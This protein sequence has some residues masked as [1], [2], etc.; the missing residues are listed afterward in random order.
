MSLPGCGGK[1]DEAGKRAVTGDRLSL[2]HISKPIIVME[3]DTFC[4]EMEQYK[5]IHLPEAGG[6]LI[7]YKDN[8]I[9]YRCV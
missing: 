5:A 7:G 2:I 3:N 6:N 1:R 4:E 9:P 8:S